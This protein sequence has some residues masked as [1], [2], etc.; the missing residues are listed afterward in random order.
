[1][2]ISICYS[3]EQILHHQHPQNPMSE[4]AQ[5]RSLSALPGPYWCLTEP[6]TSPNGPE[7]TWFPWS[8]VHPLCQLKDLK[9]SNGI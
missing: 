9:V 1:M 5:I 6:I 4:K 8:Y 3:I 7:E 2:E